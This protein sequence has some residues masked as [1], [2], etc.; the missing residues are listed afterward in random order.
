[1]QNGKKFNWEDIVTEKTNVTITL[2]RNVKAIKGLLETDAFQE[3]QGTPIYEE[4]TTVFHR[5]TQEYH[6]RLLALEAGHSSKQGDVQVE[7]THEYL[8]FAQQYHT[9]H[10]DV[11]STAIAFSK[12]LI[13]LKTQLMADTVQAEQDTTNG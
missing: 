10:T 6:M 1:M 4:A 12:I 13:N 7:E 5:L 8:Y 2:L 11:A 3:L 9:L